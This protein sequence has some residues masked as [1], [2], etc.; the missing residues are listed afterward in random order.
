[1]TRRIQNIPK[2]AWTIGLLLLLFFLGGL[3]AGKTMKKE[4]KE[5]EVTGRIFIA[6][7]EPFTQVALEQDDGLVFILTG[8]NEEELRT[9][10]GKRLTITGILG[11]RTTRGAQV[12]DVRSF[13]AAKPK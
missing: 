6:G 13:R 9:L 3:G 11:D 5:I 12:L 8:E 2:P 1:M 4:G 7:H 10:Q